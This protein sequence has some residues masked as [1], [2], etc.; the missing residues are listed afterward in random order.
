MLIGNIDPS[1][2]DYHLT[3]YGQ[4]ISGVFLQAQ[5]VSQIISAV[6]DN[7]PLLWKWQWWLEAIWVWGWSIIGG[8]LAT[9]ISYR[10]RL[11]LT[12]IVSLTG[13]FCISLIVFNHGLW[14]PL[15]PPAIAL[16]L[17][18]F[19]SD[20]TIRHLYRSKVSNTDASNLDI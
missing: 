19:M 9:Y 15:I 8:I 1:Y 13:L 5:M 11:M 10:W 2:K 3:P 14:I 6:L 20:K 17:T 7:R 16:L 4:E 12:I 18:A